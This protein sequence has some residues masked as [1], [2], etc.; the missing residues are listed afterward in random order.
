MDNN[1]E[2]YRIIKKIIKDALHEYF[3]DMWRRRKDFPFPPPPCWYYLEN[4]EDFIRSYYRFEH[5]LKHFDESVEKLSIF[6]SK[7]EEVDWG[8]ECSEKDKIE[9]I[10]GSVSTIEK[11]LQ[12]IL[13]L[14][15]KRKKQQ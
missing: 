2:L 8:S 10:V 4:E 9:K 3:I 14:L 15:E 12:K 11:N 13:E 6:V 7:L 1:Q 5:N